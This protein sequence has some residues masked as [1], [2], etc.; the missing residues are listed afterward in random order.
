MQV[1]YDNAPNER[2]ARIFVKIKSIVLNIDKTWGRRFR[3]IYAYGRWRREYRMEFCMIFEVG[4]RRR[5]GDDT[6]ISLILAFP[7]VVKTRQLLHKYF[8]RATACKSEQLF[9]CCV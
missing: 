7:V 5:T 6:G 2:I 1:L 3:G 4:L 9:Y 8:E